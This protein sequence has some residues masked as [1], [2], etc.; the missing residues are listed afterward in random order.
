MDWD[1]VIFS[2]AVAIL[3]MSAVFVFAKIK[4]RFDIID[5]AWGLVFIAIAVTSYCMQPGDM[6]LNSVQSLVTLLVVVWGYRL[7]CHIYGRWRTSD[8]EDARYD[9]MRQ[10]YSRK[11]GGVSVNMYARVFLLQAILAVVVSSSVLVVNNSWQLG[12]TWVAVLGL[13]VWLVGFYFEAAGD[14][15]LKNHLANPE[16]KG[17]L[18]TTGLWKYT[19]HPNYFGEMTQ[20][21]GI[22][23]ISLSVPQL[24]CLSIIGP[25]IITLLLLFVSGVP[26]TEKRFAG[27]TG[28]DE[29]KKRTSKV[30]PWPPGH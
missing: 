5:S 4:N 7:A 14:A 25:I 18:M 20:W 27:R 15:Q 6:M 11:P 16:N 1:H 2:A 19:R 30:F 21:W 12:I 10:S 9:A 26:L 24:W 8:V 23:I 29:Y 3:L 13:L 28:W 22:F 17:K